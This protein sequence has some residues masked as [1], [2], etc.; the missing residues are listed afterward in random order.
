VQDILSRQLY[1]IQEWLGSGTLNFFGKPFSGKDNMGKKLGARLG[2]TVIGDGDIL[3]NSYIPRAIRAEMD[4]GA[5]ISSEVYS[6]IVL[7]Y[8]G[9]AAF[10]GKPLLLSAVGRASGEEEGVLAATEAAGHP[11]KAVVHLH[12]NE[13][14]AF[15]RLHDTPDRGRSDDNDTTLRARLEAFQKETVPVLNNY[16]AMGL[17]IHVDAN[18]PKEIVFNS[19]VQQL[20]MRTTVLSGMALHAS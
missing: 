6:N 3:R 16:D 12:I 5:L 2:V 19:L 7:P 14:E 11:T 13:S 8:L 4:R 20:H 18:G 1:D 15:R 17:L 9:Q 10:H